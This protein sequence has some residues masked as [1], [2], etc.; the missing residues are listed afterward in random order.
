MNVNSKMTALADEIRELSGTTTTKSIDAMTSDVNAANA[1]ITDQTDLIAQI[2]AALEGKTGGS[3]GGSPTT[4]PVHI[5]GLGGTIVK[6]IDHSGKLSTL[7]GPYSTYDIL[8]PGICIATMSP[9]G[10][11]LLVSTAGNVQIID[12]NYTRVAFYVFG[13]GSIMA[14]TQVDMGGGA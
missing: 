10:F 6:Y 8:V 1:E 9:G 5:S 12:Q 11:E 4:A 7:T 13:E 3:S 14:D 2:T